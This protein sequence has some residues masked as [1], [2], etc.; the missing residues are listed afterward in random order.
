MG[1]FL[2]IRK[3][4]H[5]IFFLILGLTFLLPQSAFAFFHGSIGGAIGNAIGKA[6]AAVTLGI[7]SGIMLIAGLILNWAADPQVI[8]HPYTCLN[9]ICNDP[10]SGPSIVG[11]GWPVMRDFADMMLIIALVAIAIGTALRIGEYQAK[12]ALPRLLLIAFIINFTPVI[13]G[14][15]VD[16]ANIV[17]KFFLKEFSVSQLADTFVSQINSIG[18]T[19][20]IFDPESWFSFFFKL[21][22]M[23]LWVI[24]AS[25]IFLLYAMLFLMRRVVIWI[26][27]I[28]SPLAF[29]AWILP[30]TRSFF[31]RWWGQFWQWTIIGIS[32][33][34]FLWLSEWMIKFAQT[35]GEFVA[36]ASGPVG[37]FEQFINEILP[38]GL[39]IIFMLIGFFMALQTS[40][41]AAG[42]IIRGGQA[43][44]KEVTIRYPGA[45]AWIT[46]GVAKRGFRT[47]TEA[48]QR[49]YTGWKSETR[50]VSRKIIAGVA[51]TTEPVREW[52]YRTFGGRA[53]VRGWKAGRAGGRVMPVGTSLKEWAKGAIVGLP[54]ETQVG[55]GG[56][57]ISYPSV[58]GMIPNLWKR[59]KAGVE[60]TRPAA[61]GAFWALRNVA[62]KAWEETLAGYGITRPQKRRSRTCRRC[63]A[64]MKD[65]W[66]SCA[67][68]G[69][70]QPPI[71]PKNCPRCGVLS[72]PGQRYCTNCGEKLT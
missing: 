27:V 62:T 26:L 51:G 21:V 6:I 52:G 38:Y 64:P 4:L 34:F 2:A 56:T 59:A 13:L 71:P 46:G 11:I 17:M 15:I 54:A 58:P 20:N 50:G 37:Q 1:A 22:F 43:V 57:M 18:G 3:N 60:G 49:G 33:A 70:S 9:I 32:A 31:N 35:G 24:I 63:G 41:A 29:V 42:G 14:I 30:A 36:Q 44:G 7:L 53:F 48:F 47:V 12:K 68:C 19:L 5:V 66:N 65:N 72:K 40:A 39:A 69:L 16:G 45:V 8:R 55:P 28:L 61:I 25:I 67:N 10:N 23:A